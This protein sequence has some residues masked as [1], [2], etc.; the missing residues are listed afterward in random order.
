M[1]DWQRLRSEA[2][3]VPAIEG[4]PLIDLPPEELI[5]MADRMFRHAPEERRQW[6]RLRAAEQRHLAST[7]RA[8]AHSLARQRKSH[9]FW[10]RLVQH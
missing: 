9:G 5:A 1:I 6:L 8:E 4:P 3:E 7:L 10:Q 2:Q